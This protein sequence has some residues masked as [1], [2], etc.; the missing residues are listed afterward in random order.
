MHNMA[1]DAA[2]AGD[3]VTLNYAMLRAPEPTTLPPGPERVLRFE[4]TGNMDRYVWTLDNKT[5]SESDRILIRKG[6]NVKIILY[7]NSMM[8]HPMHL[9][10]HDFR[11]L[12]GQGAYAPMKNV[13]DILP[14]KT[15]TIEFAATES[16]DWFFHCH[17]LYHMMSGMGRVFSYEQSPPNPELPD[18]AYARRKLNSD[19]RMI[20]MMGMA[21]IETNGSDGQFMIANTRYRLSTEWRIGFKTHHGNESETYFRQVYGPYAM[22]LPFC[23]FRLSL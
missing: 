10:G 22:A 1:P 5:V 19:D 11:V 23:R 12:N 21:G 4:L 9:H 14:V 15:D 6:E 8:R 20:H 17:I 7:N 3:L 13:L 16:G 18:P 2:S